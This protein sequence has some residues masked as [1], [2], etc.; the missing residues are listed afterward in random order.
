MAGASE[1]VDVSTKQQRIAELA[2]Q[3]PEMGFTSLA[4]FIDIDW[5]R[6]AY[7]RTR[8]DGAVGVDGQSGEVYAVDLE[9]N[10][11]SLLNEPSPARTRHL[12]CVGPISPRP[13]RRPRPVRWASRP[14]RTRSF[15]VRSSWCSK[16]STNRT[17]RTVRTASARDGRHIK[18][19]KASGSRRWRWGR[20]DRGGRYP[21]VLRYDRPRSSACVAQ[22]SGA[23]W[24]LLRLIGKWLNAGVLEDGCLTHPKPAR[25]R[26]G[27][28]PDALQCLPALR[29]GPLVRAGR[30]TAPEGAFVPD[31]LRGR[32]RHGVLL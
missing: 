11:R 2:R 14:S 10:L 15:S 6:E 30:A 31:P 17:S 13:A 25:L 23:R 18:R 5:L 27:C 19:C 16:P 3:S 28:Q 4:Y 22:A 8:K 7:R 9:G 29:A 24:V 26:A 1:P 21:K 32:L 20:L 12:P